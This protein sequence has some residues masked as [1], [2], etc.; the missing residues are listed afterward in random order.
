M[1]RNSVPVTVKGEHLE[2][3]VNVGAMIA[4]EKTARKGFMKVL[5]EMEIGDLLPVSIL[6]G[7]CLKKN[8]KPVGV[9]FV[10]SLYFDEMEELLNPLMEAISLAFPPAGKEKNVEAVQK[11]M[12]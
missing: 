7:A 5:A 8:G 11:T 4:V 2:I 12:K 10:E 1:I 3:V 6:L 9:D